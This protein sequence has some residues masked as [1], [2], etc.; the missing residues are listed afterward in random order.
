MVIFLTLPE[1]RGHVQ[2]FLRRNGHSFSRVIAETT[3]GE[4]LDRG[5][6]PRAA[7]VFGDCQRMNDAQRDLAARIWD[8][9]TAVDGLRLLNSP[10]RQLGRYGLLRALYDKG[11]NDFNVYR[12]DELG[13]HMRFPV[14]VR[15]ENDHGGARSELLYDLDQVR[16]A[17][18]RL[19]LSG[20]RRENIL[21]VEFLNVQD[22]RGRYIKFGAFRI[23]DTIFG[24]HA[25]MATH[26]ETKMSA[27]IRD[28]EGIRLTDTY[29]QQNP[30]VELLRPLFE[31]AAVDYGRIDYAVV[32]GRIQVWEINDNPMFASAR[33]MRIT[34]LPKHLTYIEGC[35]AL[36][37]GLQTGPPIP[38][39]IDL[40]P[41]GVA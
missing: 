7:Y 2:N 11:I 36:A 31:L 35:Q 28:E 20:F 8:R 25:M 1:G 32:D 34:R 3:Y 12:L 15:I 39:D 13:P 9:L 30:H 24:H 23:G 10:R 18:S 33:M 27:A 17:A 14:F 29:Y 37:A 16:M 19:L 22:S 5:V 40:K 6:A 38:L 21:V 4:L 41:A 26:W